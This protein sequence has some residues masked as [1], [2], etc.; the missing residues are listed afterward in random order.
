MLKI[1]QSID[2]EDIKKIAQYE[3]LNFDNHE[4]YNLKQLQTINDDPLYY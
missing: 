1:S 3:Q 4:S 2:L